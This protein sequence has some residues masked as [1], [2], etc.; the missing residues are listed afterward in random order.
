MVLQRLEPNS[1]GQLVEREHRL[2]ALI[3]RYLERAFPFPGPVP[4]QVRLVQTGRMWSKPGARPMGFS[5]TE[6]FAIDRVAFCWEARFGIAAAV[7]IKVRDCYD[8]GRGVLQ[9]RALG[10]PVQRRSGPDIAVGEAYRYLAE[11]PWIPHAIAVNRDLEWEELD[12]RSVEVGCRVGGERIAVTFDFDASG[13]ISRCSAAARPRD[14]G[15]KA[16]PT[17]WG[18]QFS[19]YRTLGGIRMPVRAEVHWDL[20]GKRFVYWCGLITDACRV[21]EQFVAAAGVAR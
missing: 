10:I 12:E 7:A 15:R 21:E 3:R 4:A 16:V 6:R 19:D 11:L 20:N 5:A 2:P 1:S 14:V 13:D 18:G 17:P 9:V 8:A